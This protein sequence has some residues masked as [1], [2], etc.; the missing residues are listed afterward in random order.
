[1]LRGFFFVFVRYCTLRDHTDTRALRSFVCGDFFF[2][3]QCST[4]GVGLTFHWVIYVGYQ[5]F[6]CVDS[7]TDVT[8]GNSA[9]CAVQGFFATLFPVAL[10]T[11]VFVLSMNIFLLAFQVGIRVCVCV[12]VCL[13]VR[14]CRRIFL[15]A[16]MCVFSCVCVCVHLFVFFFHV[17]VCAFVR[18]FSSCV[19]V[20]VCVCVFCMCGFT[21][22]V[23]VSACAKVA[24]TVY[25][26]SSSSSCTGG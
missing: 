5:D 23:T 12:C 18:F 1:M 3:H 13:F 26:F 20:C 14:V 16:C 25:V 2:S 22:G 11:W 9:T 17:C 7:T 15:R 24:P 8:Q 19:C 4:L 10:S 6:L 21:F